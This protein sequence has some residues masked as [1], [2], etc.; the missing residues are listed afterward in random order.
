[1][2]ARTS[3]TRASLR[4]KLIHTAL[5][6]N[7]FRHELD[8]CQKEILSRCRAA[9]N[10]ATVEGIFERILYAL[11]R[12]IG[13]SFHPD[14]EVAVDTKRHKSF[15]RIDSRIGALVIEYK[16]CS[17]LRT[18][19][20]VSSAK[21]QL[22]EYLCSVS[23]KLP[24]PAV[25]YITDGLSFYEIHSAKGE[26]ISISGKQR[27]SVQCLLRIVRSIISLTQSA[28]TAKNLIRDFCGDVGEG[29]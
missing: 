27:M 23:E 21:S 19:T 20:H 29:V 3:S 5:Q 17:K 10:E 9:S 16:H 26:I 18:S 24:S 6:S 11:L 4:Q 25:G 8:L 1:M 13:V 7:E 28:L 2:V 22:S 12:D 15:G 14:K